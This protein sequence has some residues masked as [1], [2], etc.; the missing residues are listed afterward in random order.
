M[1]TDAS[2]NAVILEIIGEIESGWNESL[3]LECQGT[4]TLTVIYI[5]GWTKKLAAS[6][7]FLLKTKSLMSNSL[8]VMK[9]PSTSHM[10]L[11]ALHG[12]R[13]TKPETYADSNDL[14]S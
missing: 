9:N 1:G 14:K 8:K 4:N 2:P 13:T 10:I 7:S 5:S 3:L 11:Y 6:Q 12:V